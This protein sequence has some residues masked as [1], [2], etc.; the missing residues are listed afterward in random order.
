[1]HQDHQEEYQ[2]NLKDYEKQE[3]EIKRL[4]AIVERFR[5]KPTK[6]SMAMSKLKQIQPEFSMEK[7]DK[8]G[9]KLL[10]GKVLM[11]IKRYFV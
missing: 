6:A 11:R 3:K 4:T 2:K 9:L 1:M 8:K 7:I 5:Y 10:K